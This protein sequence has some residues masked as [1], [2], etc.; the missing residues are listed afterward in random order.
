MDDKQHQ[1]HTS[2]A[3]SEGN[4][5]VVME[6]YE[7]GASCCKT[8]YQKIGFPFLSGRFPNGTIMA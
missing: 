3:L 8:Y 6:Y 4:H 1:L 5:T 2:K 7:M